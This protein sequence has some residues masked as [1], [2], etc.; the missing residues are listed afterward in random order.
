VAVLERIRDNC[1]A[2]GVP[3]EKTVYTVGPTLTFD[4]QSERFTG[5]RADEANKLITRDYRTPFVVPHGV[6]TGHISP[7][8]RTLGYDSAPV[9]DRAAGGRAGLPRL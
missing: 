5:E 1:K 9:G 8:R 3:V 2:V 4:P 6:V 7:A